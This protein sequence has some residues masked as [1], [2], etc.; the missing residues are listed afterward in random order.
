MSNDNLSREW[1]LATKS[2]VQAW[3]SPAIPESGGVSPDER[4]VIVLGAEGTTFLRDLTAQR[5]TQLDLKILEPNAANFS[6]DGR[7]F[8][9]ASYMAYVRVWET[10]N[11]RE[12]ATLSGFRLGASGASFSRDGKRLAT[13]GGTNDE[14]VKLWDTESWQ[15]V[16]TLSGL[17]GNG[18]YSGLAM[19]GDGNVIGSRS[20]KGFLQIWQAPTWRE[21]EDAEKA[22]IWSDAAQ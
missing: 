18:A 20:S 11:W 22:P 4:S 10:A 16:I 8:A 21:I 9:A 6:T 1:I 17:T 12:V 19:S 3:P 15:D 2:L 5:T 13:S 14:V 7:Y